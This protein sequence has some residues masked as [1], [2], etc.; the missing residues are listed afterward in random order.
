MK[1]LIALAGAAC[2]MVG[3]ALAAPSATAHHSF[4]MFDRSHT[5][6]VRGTVREFQWSNPHAYIQLMAKDA[7]GRDVEW[8]LEMGAPMYLYARGW[9]PRTLRPGM[10]VSVDLYPLRSGEP[11]GVVVTVS[12]ASG[13]EIGTNE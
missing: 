1:K 10:E 4:A 11:G 13:K 3:L 7:Q 2:A 5:T 12:D 8:S 9:R 6:T